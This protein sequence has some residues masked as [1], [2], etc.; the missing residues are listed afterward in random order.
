MN[1]QR[2]FALPLVI[3]L[4]TISIS[5]QAGE[6]LVENNR[7]DCVIEPSE[8]VSLG[9]SASG[10]LVEV[11]VKR[12]ERV[13]KG[14][15][16]ARIESRVEEATVE[17]A[18][19]RADSVAGLEASRARLKFHEAKLKRNRHLAAQKVI[20]AEELEA[21]ETELELAQIDYR[22]AQLDKRLEKLELQRALNSLALRQITSPF[23][24]L[25]MEKV[26]DTGEYVDGSSEILRIAR[27]DPLL[28][29]SDL[30]AALFSGVTPGMAAEVYPKEAIGGFHNATVSVKDQV[31]NSKNSTFHVRL[32]L[33]NP[34]YGL[35][36]GVGCHVRF[37]P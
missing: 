13:T 1:I 22:Q 16:V 14:Q 9:S 4:W 37:L 5:L 25:V 35:P 34:N 26:L 19:A 27:L 12:G 32:E 11:N 23:D 2:A 20:S 7:F 3:G 17:L 28:V 21:L 15:L 24:G 8:I 33:A 30:P 6:V 10:V 31:L 29:Q 36:A 18:R